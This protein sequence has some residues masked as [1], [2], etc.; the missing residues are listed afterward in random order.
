M[1]VYGAPAGPEPSVGRGPDRG[2]V[3]TTAAHGWLQAETTKSQVA[4]HACDLGLRGGAACRNRTD[5]LRI[6][7]T[8]GARA[9]GPDIA[10]DLRGLLSAAAVGGMFLPVWCGL[11]A[12]CL[13]SPTALDRPGGENAV[14]TQLRR[15]ADRTE[16][17]YVSDNHG[18]RPPQ[19]GT[20]S[21]SVQGHGSPGGQVK[22]LPVQGVVNQIARG[23]SRVPLV[24]RAVGRGLIILY[25]VGRK[26]GKR[27]TVP[28]AYT[29]HEGSL[30][31]G[32]AFAWGKNLRT[33]EPLEVR[34]KGKRRLAD[35]R[36]LTDEAEVTRHYAVIARRNP[37]F[38]RFNKIGFDGDG[39]PDPN[40]LRSAWVSGARVFLLT[41]R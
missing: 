30:L 26:T 33:G 28:M 3:G 9:D 5:D 22:P 20:T 29:P 40:D 36:V 39:N 24:S 31:L 17:R 14:P 19:P 21:P 13:S 27:Y 11:G 7:R 32:S 10:A 34:F 37:G 35:V 23:L 18:Q 15:A 6:T 1:D 25:V 4:D 8:I 16:G 38:A 41:L 12:D 2:P